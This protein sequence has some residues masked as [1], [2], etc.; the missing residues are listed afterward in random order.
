MTD[1][2]GAV[3]ALSAAVVMAPALAHALELP[4]KLRLDR[5]HYFAV[6]RIYSPGFTVA[7][8]SEV[9]AVI[10]AAVA[11]A[12]T[13]AA[14]AD[15]TLRATGL[16]A[17]VGMQAVYWLRVHP[18]NGF[19]L[20]GEDLDR[21]SRRFFSFAARRREPAGEGPVE[22]TTLRTR[23]ESGHAVRAVLSVVGVVVLVVALV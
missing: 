7:G 6:Q 3:A 10:M 4:G 23:W 17:L 20:A 15:F 22:W 11:L 5:D 9:P 2:V 12:L 13:E 16:A 8:M 1:V 18:V 19:W 14:S 21:F